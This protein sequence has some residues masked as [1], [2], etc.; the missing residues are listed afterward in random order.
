MANIVRQIYFL[1][2]LLL[3]HRNNVNNMD[4]RYNLIAKI[5]KRMLLQKRR[6]QSWWLNFPLVTFM[7][8]RVAMD[9][10]PNKNLLY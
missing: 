10:Q 6:T 9:F 7:N 3:L 8:K 4:T 5:I 1:N 2:L